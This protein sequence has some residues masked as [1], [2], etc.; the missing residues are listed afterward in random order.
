MNSEHALIGYTNQKRDSDF[1]FATKTKTLFLYRDVRCFY[2]LIMEVS[3][4]QE[5]AVGKVSKEPLD[6]RGPEE[7]ASTRGSCEGCVESAGRRK[8]L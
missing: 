4:G 5:E 1:H 2:L 6:K 3:E 7:H 8:G